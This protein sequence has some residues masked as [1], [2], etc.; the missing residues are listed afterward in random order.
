[1]VS[2]NKTKVRSKVSDE[3]LARLIEEDF[4]RNPSS[5][6][7]G[8]IDSDESIPSSNYFFKKTSAIGIEQIVK[9][10]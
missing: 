3:E 2:E 5:Y 8:P 1:M 10:L 4:K 9:W 7:S 6:S